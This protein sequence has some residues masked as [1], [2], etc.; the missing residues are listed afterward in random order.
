MLDIRFVRENPDAVKENIKKKF[1]EAKLPLVDQVIALDEEN[2]PPLARPMSSAPAA[3]PCPNKWVCSWVRQKRSLQAGGGGGGQGPGQGQ[4]R[5]SGGAGGQGN[6]MWP[7]RSAKIMLQIPNIIDPSV[8]IGPDDSANV[9]GRS[10]LGNPRYR[11]SLSPTTLKLWSP[12]AASTWTP[13]A[14]YRATAST[15]CWETSPGCMR[16]CWP[17]PETL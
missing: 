8:P 10:G 16:Q 2:R 5:P 4:R 13:P 1:Q 9:G 3:T 7:P 17:M 11:T 14:G 15:I 12:S 6:P